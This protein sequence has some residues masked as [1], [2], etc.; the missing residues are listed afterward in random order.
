MAAALRAPRQPALMNAR[1][2]AVNSLLLRWPGLRWRFR[3][4]GVLYLDLAPLL[5]GRFL[6]RLLLAFQ[7]RVFCSFRAIALDEKQRR[8]EQHDANAGS[9]RVTR[10][11]GIDFSL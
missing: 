7:T 6:Q 8:P 10:G 1:I 2:V 11:V 5:D 3:R 9:D 4:D